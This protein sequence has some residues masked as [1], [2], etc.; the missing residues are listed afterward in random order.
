MFAPPGLTEKWSITHVSLVSVWNLCSPSLWPRIFMTD[1]WPSFKSPN[2]LHSCCPDLCCCSRG[3]KGPS[4]HVSVFCWALAQKA[5]MWPCSG[6][7]FIAHW[8]ESQCQDC[9][10]PTSLLWCLGTLL[11]SG[12]L[13]VTL[14]ILRP[15]CPFWDSALIHHL[16]TFKPGMSPTSADL[17]FPILCSL[18]T[19]VCGGLLKLSLYPSVASDKSHLIHVSVRLTFQK[20][21]AF[22]L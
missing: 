7:Y 18:L 10:Q 20:V 13:F 11:Q 4:A 8:E 15:C 12:I 22:L 5:V 16:S 14:G 19:K 2:F 6:S 21:I 3:S 1:M 9:F 17:Q